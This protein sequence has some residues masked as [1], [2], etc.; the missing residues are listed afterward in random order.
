MDKKD[1]RIDKRTQEQAGKDIKERR[2][3]IGVS[4]EGLAKEAGISYRTVLRFENGEQIRDKMFSKIVNAL[5]KL[6]KSRQSQK[7]QS[8]WWLSHKR[9]GTGV[10]NRV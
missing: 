10:I 9:P 5:K 3:R 4:Q 2:E 6:E 1:Q 8:L 7:K